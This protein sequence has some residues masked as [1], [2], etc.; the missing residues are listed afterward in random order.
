MKYSQS[1]LTYPK[2]IK[3]H[4][5]VIQIAVLLHPER[6]KQG[7]KKAKSKTMEVGITVNQ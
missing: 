1:N 7:T 5:G 2:R 6:E 4:I 3:S